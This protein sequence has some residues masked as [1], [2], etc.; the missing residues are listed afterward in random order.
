[1]ESVLDIRIENLADAKYPSCSTEARPEVNVDVS[2][3]IKNGS[4]N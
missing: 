3:V 2:I 4:R 1:M